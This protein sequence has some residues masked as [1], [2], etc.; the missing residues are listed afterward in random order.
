MVALASKGTLTHGCRHGWHKDIMFYSGLEIFGET[1]GLN[2]KRLFTSKVLDIKNGYENAFEVIETRCGGERND[3]NMPVIV[4][5]IQRSTKGNGERNRLGD[6][7]EAAN[8][9][10]PSIETLTDFKQ[11]S[12]DDRK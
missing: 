11:I 8:G 1:E 7:D 2:P 3:P 12:R 4:H 6:E 10:R 5:H 9:Q